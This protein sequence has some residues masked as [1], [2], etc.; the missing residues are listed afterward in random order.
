M[1][2]GHKV[3]ITVPTYFMSNGLLDC[4]DPPILAFAD[5]IDTD[6]LPSRY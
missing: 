4:S 5:T 2:Q 1:A 6:T 3:L